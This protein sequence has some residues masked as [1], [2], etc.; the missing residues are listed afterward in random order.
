MKH[1]S[2]QK[3][4]ASIVSIMMFFVLPEFLSAQKHCPPNQFLVC[5]ANG[6][7]CNCQSLP[8]GPCRTCGT[9]FSNAKSTGIS[10]S[11]DKPEKVSAKVYDMTGRLVKTVPGKIFEQGDRELQWNAAGLNEGLYLVQ[12]NSGAYSE[13]K[14]VSIVK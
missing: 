3:L 4:F 12:F 8:P 2:P 6:K 11:L 9:F 7:H 5:D 14:K 10:F 1:Q 13:I